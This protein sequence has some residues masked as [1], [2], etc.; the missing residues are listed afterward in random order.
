MSVKEKVKRTAN[1]AFTLVKNNITLTITLGLAFVLFIVLIALTIGDL[2]TRFSHEFQEVCHWDSSLYYTVGHALAEGLSPYADMYENKP[3]M[4]FILSAI[5]YKLFGNYRLVNITGFILLFVI[6]VIPIAFCIIKCVKN[7]TE[8]VKSVYLCLFTTAASIS[9]VFFT[10]E[11]SGEAQ[12]E[13]LGSG[14]GL[15]SIF[16]ASLINEDKAKFYSPLVIFSGICFGITTM[17]KEPFA[18]VCG[19]CL[20]LFTRNLKQLL[21]RVVLPVGY[22]VVT[23]L[24]ILLAGNC[25]V[26]YFT[27]YL[28]NMFSSHITLYGSPFERMKSIN[29]IFNYSYDFAKVLPLI[30]LV[31]MFFTGVYGV[32]T[33]YS[34][35][36]IVNIIFKCIGFLKP[37][38][39]MYVT[40]FVVGLGGQYFNH[41]FVFA[42]PFFV[43]TLMIMVKYLAEQKSTFF[44]KVYKQEKKKLSLLEVTNGPVPDK[45]EF[46]M[47]FLKS[48]AIYPLIA[49]FMII[50]FNSYSN[51]PRFVMNNFVNVQ[52]EVPEHKIKAAY[53][54]DI[55]DTLN[56]ENYLWI[57]FNG[58]TPCPYTKHLPLGPSFAQDTNNFQ[59]ESTFYA[60]AFIKHLEKADVVITWRLHDYWVG[61]L[62]EQTEEYLYEN[63]TMDMPK[64]VVDANLTV[65]EGFEYYIFYRISAFEF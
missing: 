29:K 52:A 35:N 34:D 61:V 13:L 1:K 2:I 54:D 7:K 65:P 53:F 8:L 51:I 28:K 9:I 60:Q 31:S 20:L 40:S 36:V 30:Y 18:L 42:T 59:K 19:V 38:L 39:F 24:I 22:A 6:L 5:S 4:I 55:L 15:L 43:S 3:P 41:H 47:K 57:G 63:F 27:I 14:F 45:N 62:A 17:L 44:T 11:K 33:H 25:F 16:L 56:Q 32:K 37:I 48:F 46:A 12:V 10:Q 50:S 58:Y 21:Y 49:C 23:A 64:A 26:P